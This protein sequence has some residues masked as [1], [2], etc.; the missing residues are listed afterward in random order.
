MSNHAC[1]SEL[2]LCGGADARLA[3]AYILASARRSQPPA[4][5]NITIA[6]DSP[7]MTFEI[8]QCQRITYSSF[9]TAW[10][11]G[12]DLIVKDGRGQ[13]LAVFPLEFL[14]SG[15]VNT[16]SFVESTMRMM[17]ACE[18]DSLTSSDGQVLPSDKQVEAGEVFM[19]NCQGQGK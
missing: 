2:Q 6:Q 14:E 7:C 11:G 12:R 13:Q 9:E 17:Y 15:H 10:S 8:E 5:Y 18:G 4:T 1:A 16:Y 3:L 19:P